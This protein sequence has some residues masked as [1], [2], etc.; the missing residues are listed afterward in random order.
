MIVVSKRSLFGLALLA[1]FGAAQAETYTVINLGTIGGAGS[2]TAAGLS[3]NGIVVGQSNGQ[4]YRWTMGGGMVGLNGLG[5][6]TTTANAVNSSGQIA[7]RSD[8]GGGGFHA[9]LWD[10]SVNATDLGG[11]FSTGNG[12]NEAG[13]V[14][15]TSNS[16][17]FRKTYGGAMFQLP[18]LDNITISNAVNTGGT[19]TG[20]SDDASSN[21]HA[22]R[23]NGEANL[24]D[25]G[26]P[27]LDSASQGQAINDSNVV[28]GYTTRFS[29]FGA[30]R[31]DTDFEI[32]NGLYNYDTRAH[33]INNDGDAVGHS[34]LSDDGSVDSRAV[35]WNAGNANAINLNDHIPGFETEWI[36]ERATDINNNGQIVGTGKFNGQTRAFLLTPVPEPGTI[37]AL[38]LGA[39]ALLKKKR[40]R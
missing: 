37:A 21:R 39:L 13:T 2:S 22:Y 24:E 18:T 36:L 19:V 5:G 34:W 35:L 23:W 7:G 9:V 16:R 3:D 20:G 31:F 15:G 40:R 11:T 29:T 30:F 10:N 17:G 4:A 38:G 14:V 28:A 8:L 25:L 6:A 32:L 1:A 33:G 26:I 27:V 12:I